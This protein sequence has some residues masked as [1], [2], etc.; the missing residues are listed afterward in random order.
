MSEVLVELLRGSLVDAVHRGDLAVV[1]SFGRLLAAVGDPDRVAYMRS[2]AKPFQSMPTVYGGAAA[3]W[4]L[5]PEDLAI[6]CGSHNGEPVHVARVRALLA[7]IGR[8]V[9]DLA[10]GVHPPL[11]EAAAAA[12]VR[13]GLLP[14]PLHHNCSGLH[15]GMLAVALHLGRD[16]HGYQ[17]P[18]H[19][20]QQ[21]ILTNVA[22]FAGAARDTIVVGTDGCDSPCHG[23]S[24]Y[25]MA[26][27]YARLMD[28]VDIAEP[29][30]ESAAVVRDAMTTHPHLV[31]GTG[32]F[33]TDLMTVSGGKVLA[34]AAPER[35]S[36]SACRG[37]GS[38]GEDRRRRQRPGV[39]GTS[40]G[41]RRD[42]GITADRRAGPPP[43]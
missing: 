3:R 28:P 25:H 39:P 24:L 4:S 29:Y 31:G 7:K 12:L 23:V 42:R 15:S 41:R 2:S 5:E 18:D 35:C 8:E 19:P 10:C 33:D 20:V 34:K 11:Y 38:C 17:K 9:D 27:A 26:Y 36:A 40:D 6:L 13:Q 16:S 21:Q 30:A 43:R 22:R 1:D 14:T 32:R 37:P